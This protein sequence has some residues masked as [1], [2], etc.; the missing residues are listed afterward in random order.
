[1]ENK[2][3]RKVMVKNRSTSVVVL[4][5]PN[6]HIR[7]ELQPGQVLSTLTFSD[8][9]EFSYQPGGDAIL[10]EY[11]QLAEIETKQLGL[12]E[13]Q[14]EYFYSE[15]DIQKLLKEGSLDEFLDC[16]DFAPEG[17]IDLIKRFSVSLPLT[18]TRKLESL[19]EKTGF[20]AAAAIENVK[21]EQ[22]EV[23]GATEET[24]TRRVV[25]ADSN[26]SQPTR[27]VTK[28]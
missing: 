18:D 6:R 15:A 1:M 2:K 13:P 25:K 20:D 12:G 3:N 24:P 17:V 8:L 10:R 27:R 16:L 21:K 19:K 22:A 9:E 23:G 14:P 26:P 11:L 28:K 5:V 7:V 4:T